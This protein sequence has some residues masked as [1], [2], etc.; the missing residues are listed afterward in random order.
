M[1]PPPSAAFTAAANSDFRR[2]SLKIEALWTDPFVMS[3]NVVTSPNVNNFGD[4]DS[5]VVEDF[6]LQTANTKTATP[7]K[8]IVNDGTWINDGTWYPVPG[9][10]EEAAD[11]EVGW[12]SAEVAGTSGGF[13]LPPEMVITFSEVRSVKQV[14]VAGESTLNEYPTDFNVYIYDSSTNV[15]NTETHFTSSTIQNLLDFTDDEIIDAKSMKLVLNAWSR[16][17]TIGKITEFFGVIADTFYSDDIV[18]MDVLE[19]IEAEGDNPAVGNVSSNELNMEFQNVDITKD[20]E[21]VQDPFL[22]ENTASYLKNSITPNVRLTPYIG[23]KLPDD[24]IEYVK[25]GVFWSTDWDVSE[26]DFS[27]SVTA[28]DRFELLRQNTFLQNE[29][30]SDVTLTE[31]AEYVLNKARIDIP[32]NDLEWSISSDLNDF[33][34][35][36]VWFGE[37]TYFEALS[38]IA[39][40]CVGRAYCDR[41]GKIIVETYKSNQISGSE[42]FTISDHFSATREMCELKNYIK[43]PVCNLVPEE[44]ADTV[45][46]S[47]EIFVRNTEADVTQNIRWDDDAVVE[48]EVVITEQNL[49]TVVVINKKF[50]PWGAEITFFNFSGTTGSFKY[51]ITGK[52]LKLST[53]DTVVVTDGDS[54]GLYNKQEHEIPENFLVQ[55]YEVALE[56]ATAALSCMSN[57]RRDI[58]LEVPGNPCTE[59]GDIA[60]IRT[61]KKLN[62]YEEFRVIRQQFKAALQGGLS[63]QITGRKTI[64]YGG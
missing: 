1:R 28:R 7:H 34:V 26:G 30:L 11:N 32:L 8:Y 38:Q 51:K 45:Y 31:V 42:D 24:S 4:L 12:Y 37:V 43:S 5:E 48:H 54:I 27:A 15:L 56:I 19:E 63:C 58:E 23:F 64:D 18:S 55:T 9:T 20:G 57:V 46:E 6:L 29:I 10:I 60:S 52:K 59:P 61:Y 13:E 40:A 2:P 3:G 33:T 44:E 35:N 62:I 21:T 41:D 16:G 53:T 17:D 39:A 25:M 22:P 36:N 50:Y 47:E 49:I 14:L